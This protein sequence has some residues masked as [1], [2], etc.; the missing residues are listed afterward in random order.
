M[1]SQAWVVNW[2]PSF[3]RQ[4]QKNRLSVLTQA[5]QG[6]SISR[7]GFNMRNTTDYLQYTWRVYTSMPLLY[8][9]VV[10][11]SDWLPLCVDAFDMALYQL[12]MGFG[13]GLIFLLS[14]SPLWLA[15]SG[16]SFLETV[17]VCASYML[18]PDAS[19]IS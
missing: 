17:I 12:Q 1:S 15:A 3:L 13:V 2:T 4:R 10:S 6:A 7:L 18:A 16:K 14:V 8:E 9:P 5:S 11:G 19:F